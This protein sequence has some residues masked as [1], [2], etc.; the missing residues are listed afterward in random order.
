VVDPQ[1]EGKFF[2]VWSAGTSP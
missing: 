2:S 1:P